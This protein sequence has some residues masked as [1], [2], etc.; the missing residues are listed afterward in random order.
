MHGHTHTAGLSLR[1]LLPSPAPCTRLSD[2]ALC[3]ARS[4]S[5]VSPSCVSLSVGVLPFHLAPT[6]RSPWWSG[7]W[8]DG[9]RGCPEAH[10]LV[11]SVP[12]A[13]SPGSPPVWPPGLPGPEQHPV[14][15]AAFPGP[16]LCLS[17][18]PRPPCLPAPGGAPRAP[19]PSC[20]RGCLTAEDRTQDRSQRFQPSHRKTSRFC[21]AFFRPSCPARTGPNL[22]DSCLFPSKN[23][24]LPSPKR[25][26]ELLSLRLWGLCSHG[27][28]ARGGQVGW[29]S[30]GAPRNRERSLEVG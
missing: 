14:P 2:L 25:L 1:G 15:L 16:M 10:A 19:V 7:C 21:G 23:R 9:G 29:V 11:N 4:W 6:A 20:P 12:G 28:V 22:C 24:G 26:W 3:P 18:P 30:T 17:S 5:P 13:A 8:R 27:P